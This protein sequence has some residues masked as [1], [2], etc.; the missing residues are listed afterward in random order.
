M[1][2]QYFRLKYAGKDKHKIVYR[3]RD[4]HGGTL[5]VLAATGQDERKA[6]YGPLPEGFVQMP[7]A[8]CY[9]CHFGKTYPG[10]NIDCARALETVIQSE[11]PDTVAAVILEPI[12]AGGGIIIPV[13]EYYPII[14]EI[15]RKYEV[16]IIMDEVVNGFG[17]TGK[18]FGS[19]HYDF[20]PDIMTMA[21]GLASSYMPIS[22]TMTKK[23]IF[24][25]FL[26]EPSDTLGY[27][28]DISTFGG[29]AAGCAAALANIAVIEDQAMVANSQIMGQYLLDQ[30]QELEGMPVVG[31]IRGKGLF[32]GIELVEI[33]RPKLRSRKKFWHRW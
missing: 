25:E 1:A 11:G 6:G 27:F 24:D 2:R 14:Q 7:H 15:C 19:Q 17:R 16:L 4:Y 3:H 26:A 13:D 28:R 20:D 21:K 29:C 10:C 30:L 5:A 31:Q 8:L 33:K 22:A 9:R 32:F 12:T 18:M 23:F